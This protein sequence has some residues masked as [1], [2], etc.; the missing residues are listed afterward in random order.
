MKVEL[1]V[2]EHILPKR[3]PEDAFVCECMFKPINL[4][5]HEGHA[6]WLKAAGDR[7]REG[8]PICEADVN[9]KTVEFLAPCSGTI[10]EL[11]VPE[12][13][14]FRAGTVLCRI[15]GDE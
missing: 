12:G 4:Q 14:S 5:K 7:V 2:P 3:D 9:K 6:M 8:E 11:A 13:G 15:E 10:S 1:I